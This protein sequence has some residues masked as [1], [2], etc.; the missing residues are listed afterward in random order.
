MHVFWVGEK[1][2]SRKG[3]ACA[4]VQGQVTMEFNTISEIDLWISG[5]VRP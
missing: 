3:Q 2:Q 1:E 5:A 4:K